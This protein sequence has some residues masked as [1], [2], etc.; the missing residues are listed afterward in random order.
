MSNGEQTA[1]RDAPLVPAA[2]PDPRAPGFEMP[3]GAV[4]CHAHVVLPE[5]E[6]PFHHDRSYTPP[7]ALAKDYAR[8]HEVL[9]FE[10][11]VIVQPSFYGA[12]NTVTR[13]A[14][15]ASNGRWR[16]VAVVSP[17]ISLDEL[18]ALDRDGFRGVRL[19]LVF[20]GGLAMEAAEM[21]APKMAEFGWHLQFLV[22]VSALGDLSW[23]GRLACP[24]VI[25]HMGHFDAAKGVE[26]PGFQSL[27]KLLET[28]RGWVKLSGAYR[29]TGL[30]HPPY[31][32]VVPIARALVAARPDRLVYGTDWP[33]PAVRIPMPNDG[34][35]LDELAVWAPDPA[36]R[37]A[38]L[39][40]NPRR[41]YGF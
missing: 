19:N 6:H 39:V 20:K 11:G 38:I 22:D 7:P 24:V 33:H 9:G 40:D 2:D 30:Q 15:V 3:A 34:P 36:Q 31:T 5:S 1:S 16:G 10:Y 32:D 25:D 13:D 12:D 8:L 17:E 4:D 28:G 14:M 26:E 35:L 18:R 21:L 41:L 27:L 29:L 23:M 37:K